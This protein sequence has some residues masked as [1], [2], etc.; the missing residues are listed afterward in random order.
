[1]LALLS[2]TL[3]CSDRVRRVAQHHPDGGVLLHH[4]TLGVDREDLVQHVAVPLVDLESVGQH[5][6]REGLVLQRHGAGAIA[7]Y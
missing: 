3:L 4:D 7:P 6:P 1:M 2:L 5:D